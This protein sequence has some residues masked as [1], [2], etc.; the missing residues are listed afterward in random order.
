MV[1]SSYHRP[2][3]IQGAENPRSLFDKLRT[4]RIGFASV[5]DF[6]FEPSLS[7]HAPAFFSIL[8]CRNSGEI[9]ACVRIPQVG[10]P[11]YQWNT[12]IHPMNTA[13]EP[14][15]LR[16]RYK[17]IHTI[18]DLQL[19]LQ[20]ALAVEL[21]TIPPY[22]TAL[23]SIKDNSSDAYSLIKSVAIEEMLHLMLVSNLL[24]STGATPKLSGEYV[25]RYPGFIP[26]HAAGGPY[27]Q[28]QTFSPT[29]MHT[30]FMAIEQ[31]EP[32]PSAPS[33]GDHFQTIGQFY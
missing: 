16:K 20:W 5:E 22:L 8:L 28:L 17:P 29:L 2:Y 30:T 12:R 31:P 4:N 7:K 15:P 10:T 27:I 32:S 1:Y 18:P 26:H 11:P 21:A 23:Y 33:E 3:A 25:P 24:N 19:H 13:S 6:P 14:T 9:L